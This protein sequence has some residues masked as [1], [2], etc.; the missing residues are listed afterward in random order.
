[1]PVFGYLILKIGVLEGDAAFLFEDA[2]FL[3]QGADDVEEDAV[4]KLAGL[5]GGVVV[6]NLDVL[7]HGDGEGNFG[8][9]DELADSGQ[10][11]DD[12]H[13]R[14]SLGVPAAGVDEA[15]DVLIDVE[16]D[17]NG[18]DQRYRKKVRT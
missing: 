11:H 12:V 9:V 10:H 6:G 3:A 5:A 2:A 8:I 7:V 16:N 13:K 1:M 14:H 18:D 4:D 17:G 15:V